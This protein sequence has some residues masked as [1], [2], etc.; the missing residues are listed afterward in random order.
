MSKIN[1]NFA[2]SKFILTIVC[3][4][5]ALVLAILEKDVPEGVLVAAITAYNAAN[6]VIKW[7]RNG[8]NDEERV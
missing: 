2:S 1:P 4:L 6:A 8:A 5:A 3:V 7:H